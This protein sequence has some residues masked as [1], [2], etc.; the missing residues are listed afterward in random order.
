M[1]EGLKLTMTGEELRDLLKSRADGHRGR[2][3]SWR[4]EIPRGPA[5]TEEALQ[6]P[7][8]IRE[9]EADRHEWRAEVLDFLRE[10]LEPLE[11]Y[12]LSETD[13][14]F[15][16]L[17]PGKPAALEQDEYEE[18]TGLGFELGGI[19]RRLCDAPEIVQITNPDYLDKTPSRDE[20]RGA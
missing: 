4:R 12:R 13:L 20:S 16:E 15:G 18:R 1:I 8:H 5:E 7:A 19:S 3:E 14:E 10:H 9:H 6:L 2:A 17:L 11:V